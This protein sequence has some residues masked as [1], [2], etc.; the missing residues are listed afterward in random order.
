MDLYQ[1]KF[2]GILY[3]KLSTIML[4]RRSTGYFKGHFWIFGILGNYFIMARAPLWHVWW[5]LSHRFLCYQLE[6]YQILLTGERSYQGLKDAISF[7][8]LSD[9]SAEKL[10]GENSN[11]C[12]FSILATW[13]TQSLCVCFRM[14]IS[15]VMSL[16]PHLHTKTLCRRWSQN[17]ENWE[18]L[19]ISSQITQQLLNGISPCYGSK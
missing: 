7:G 10:E 15:Q 17:M 9:K 5:G 19:N 1:T 13:Q 6:S 3:H 4:I 11:I 16:L 12:Q 14:Q 18:Y 8:L 2:L